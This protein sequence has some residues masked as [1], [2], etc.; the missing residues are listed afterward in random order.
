MTKV[1]INVPDSI[2]TG[3]DRRWDDC[4]GTMNIEIPKRKLM[5]W[6][7]ERFAQSGCK[8]VP[9]IIVAPVAPA[10]PALPA[11]G[12]EPVANVTPASASGDEPVANVTPAAT[13]TIDGSDEPVANVTPAAPATIDGSDEPVANVT[14]AS[15]SGDEPVANVTVDEPVIIITVDAPDHL[16]NRLHE[17]WAS[18][19]GSKYMG[20]PKRKLILWALERFVKHPDQSPV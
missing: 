2:V 9:A 16:L 5:L 11:S 6:A 7:L 10:L 15:A 4:V 19:I 12:D 1:T 13:A 17:M 20:L 14:P 8:M 3:V 18:F